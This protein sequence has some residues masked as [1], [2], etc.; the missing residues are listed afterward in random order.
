MEPKLALYCLLGTV[1]R[2]TEVLVSISW[3]S[4]LKGDP[5]SIMWWFYFELSE[6]PLYCS[7]SPSFSSLHPEPEVSEQYPKKLT[8][9]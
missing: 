2:W 4:T 1:L 6:E 9:S 8:L 3:R 7:P 5:T